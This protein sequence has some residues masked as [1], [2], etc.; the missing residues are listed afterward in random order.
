MQVRRAVTRLLNIWEERKVFAPLSNKPF[1]DLITEAEGLRSGLHMPCAFLMQHW[2]STGCS[3]SVASAL[4][5][6]PSVSSMILQAL[7]L[8]RTV[9]MFLLNVRNKQA[10]PG[11]PEIETAWL[12]LPLVPLGEALLLLL[13]HPGMINALAQRIL[14]KWLLPSAA[15][16]KPQ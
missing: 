16:G 15:L 13:D 10:A 7:Y 2:S 12:R 11:F 4:H 8:Q 5:T 9:F 6:A 14:T 3:F 1:L